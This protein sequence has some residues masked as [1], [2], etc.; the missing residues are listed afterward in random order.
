MS[1][2]ETSLLQSMTLGGGKA[3]L[4]MMHKVCSL[5]ELWV[6]ACLWQASYQITRLSR[7]MSLPA[8]ANMRETSNSA[9]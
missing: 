5:P 4:A 6:L 7:P 9:T 3:S 8:I 1:I 2:E